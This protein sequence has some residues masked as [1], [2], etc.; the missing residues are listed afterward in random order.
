MKHGL[1][2]VGSGGRA[3]SRPLLRA[4]LVEHIHIQIYTH[5]HISNHNNIVYHHFLEP[6]M[7]QRHQTCELRQGVVSFL[8]GHS[9]GARRNALDEKSERSERC[10]RV[11]SDGAPACQERVGSGRACARPGSFLACLSMWFMLSTYIVC[12]YCYVFICCYCV[13]LFLSAG[14]LLPLQS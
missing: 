7:S 14:I 3:E 2:R 12:G 5:I 11:L 4:L 8:W 9:F 10:G 6:S 13:L 1:H